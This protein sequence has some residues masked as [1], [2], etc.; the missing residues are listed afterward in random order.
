[1]ARKAKNK[2]E[3]KPKKAAKA[4]AAKAKR[5]RVGSQAGWSDLREAGIELHAAEVL[6]GDAHGPARTALPHLRAF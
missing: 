3:P 6:I 2:A 5:G 1:M 4:K